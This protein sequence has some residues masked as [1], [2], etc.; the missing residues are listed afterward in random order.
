[1]DFVTKPQLGI[2]EGMLAYSEL[3]AEDSHRRQS[4]PAAA[5]QQPGAGDPQ[6]CAAAE[7]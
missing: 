7:Q 5:F 6:P 3:I 2:R 1:M 4:A